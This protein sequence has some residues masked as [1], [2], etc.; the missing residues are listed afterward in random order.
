MGEEADP[1]GRA[2][3]LRII[4]NVRLADLRMLPEAELIRRYDWLHTHPVPMSGA[5]AMSAEDYLRELDRREAERLTR[6][7][8]TLTILVALLTLINTIAAVVQVIAAV[9]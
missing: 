6:R 1:D 4:A 9:R 7:I 5:G 2:E 8:T 3:S